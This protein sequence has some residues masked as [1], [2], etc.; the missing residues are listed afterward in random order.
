MLFKFPKNDKNFSW[1]QHVKNKML[2]YR[3]S[4][5]KRADE[6]RRYLIEC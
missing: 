4:E 2:Y 6:N 1:T 5:Q 3:L